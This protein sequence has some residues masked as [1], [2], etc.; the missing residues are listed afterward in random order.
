MVSKSLRKFAI[1][2]P[3]RDDVEKE[4]EV[5]EAVVADVVVADEEVEKAAVAMAVSG[6]KDRKKN[7]VRKEK[8]LIPCKFLYYCLSELHY[9]TELFI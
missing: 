5:D 9:I 6:R 8:A 2:G 4:E 7:F 3:G 1:V